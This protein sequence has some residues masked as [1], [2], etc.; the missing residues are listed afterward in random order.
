MISTEMPTTASLSPSSMA[1]PMCSSIMEHPELERKIEVQGSYWP[2]LLLRDYKKKDEK[3]KAH[4]V[5]RN[6][7]SPKPFTASMKTP[8]SGSSLLDLLHEVPSIPTL[9]C[10][11]E[12]HCC[13]ARSPITGK[14]ILS[15]K[16]NKSQLVPSKPVRKQL[17]R[18]S[19]DETSFSLD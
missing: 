10:E 19:S 12:H 6:F 17:E 5:R 3:K 11:E 16:T 13:F 4:K 9:V 8:M 1:K 14:P 15:P 2:R 18:Q 7:K